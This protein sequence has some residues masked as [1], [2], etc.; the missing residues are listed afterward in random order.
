[1][2]N[3]IGKHNTIRL[4][5]DRRRRVH[6]T[7]IRVSPSSPSQSP[8][9]VRDFR[10]H[11]NACSYHTYI[12]YSHEFGPRRR[13]IKLYQYFFFQQ[14][15]IISL[16]VI[17]FPLLTTNVHSSSF[18]HNKNILTIYTRSTIIV[19]VILRYI[20]IIIWYLSLSY[21]YIYI[22]VHVHIFLLNGTGQVL[23][24]CDCCTC[25][26]R[27]TT[28]IYTDYYLLILSVMNEP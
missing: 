20:I 26:P 27:K 9:R 14:Q 18:S 8:H 19:D 10:S 24:V 12:K 16:Y 4:I 1:M 2:Y 6:V 11:K 7:M 5:I 22:Y 13:Y 15:A 3:R 17:V 21:I 23:R 25:K 28:P